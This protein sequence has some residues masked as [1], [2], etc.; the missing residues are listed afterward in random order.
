MPQTQSSDGHAHF[1][2]EDANRTDTTDGHWHRIIPGLTRTGPE[3]RVG[4]S[5]PE[6]GDGHTH[7]L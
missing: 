1:Y 6:S 2:D 3:I 5:T 7:R 4:Q